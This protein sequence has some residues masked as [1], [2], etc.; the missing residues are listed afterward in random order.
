MWHNGTETR[1]VLVVDV[2]HPELDEGQ[3]REAL[4]ASQQKE[5]FVE[6]YKRNR[7]V[8]GASNPDNWF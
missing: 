5:Q 1:I 8:F 3:R 7:A 6:A 4:L 2:W